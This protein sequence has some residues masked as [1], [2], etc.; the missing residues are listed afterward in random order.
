MGDTIA[1][2]IITMVRSVSAH[3]HYF[4]QICDVSRVISYTRPSSPLFFPRGGARRGRPGDEAKRAV[5]GT[6]HVIVVL[7]L[8]LLCGLVDWNVPFSGPFGHQK[9][10]IFDFLKENVWNLGVKVKDRLFCPDADTLAA[11]LKTCAPLYDYVFVSGG[12]VPGRHEGITA[13]G[14]IPG[15]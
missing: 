4:S 6:M 14:K 9:G 15:P 8:D 12:V 13:D 11:E 10:R 5:R 7:M 1:S 2:L 3:I